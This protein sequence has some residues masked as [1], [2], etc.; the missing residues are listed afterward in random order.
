MARTCFKTPKALLQCKAIT[1]EQL[2]V[3]NGINTLQSY[4]EYLID[5]KRDCYTGHQDFSGKLDGRLYQS[6][7]KQ[8][9]IWQSFYNKIIENN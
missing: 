3:Q 9:E 1:P 2:Y 5:E 8:L 4:I 7:V 6:Y